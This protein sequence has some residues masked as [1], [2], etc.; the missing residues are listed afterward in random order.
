MIEKLPLSLYIHYPFCV[1]KCPYCDFN[2]YKKSVNVKDEDYLKALIADFHKSSELIDGRKISTVYIGGGT[3]S[4]FGPKNVEKLVDEISVY[5]HSDAEISMEA[6]PGTVTLDSLKDYRLAGINRIS[7]GVQSFND[8]SLKAL[9]RIHDGRVAKECCLNVIKAG[10]D[11]YNADIMHGLPGQSVQMALQ[12]L[13]AAYEC[14]ANHLSWYELTIEE[15]TRFGAHPPELPDEETLLE[16]EESGFSY[17]ASHG[18]NRYE[19]SGYTKDRKCRHNLNYWYFGDYLGIGAG[20]HGKVKIGDKTLRRACAQNVQD[21]LGEVYSL[22]NHGHCYQEVEK[23][24]L[25]FEFMLNRLRVFNEI[26]TGEFFK[27][28]GIPFSVVEG[29]LLEAQKKGLINFTDT[30]YSLTDLG[31]LML[32]DI[33]QMFL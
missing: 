5:L 12:D 19:V 1:R 4:L 14:G 33:L 16:I 30:H 26:E 3:P 8:A 24:Q 11:N 18:F 17:L 7:V 32:N 20:A 27:T 28:T 31:K 10:F 23:D 25:P 13:A 29:R 2:S 6:N 15:D 21:Y 9:G 22:S